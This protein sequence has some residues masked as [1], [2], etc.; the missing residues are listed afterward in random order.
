MVQICWPDI[1][2]ISNPSNGVQLTFI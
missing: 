1:R 2:E